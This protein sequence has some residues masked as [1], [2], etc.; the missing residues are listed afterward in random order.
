M[1]KALMDRHMYRWQM[2]R[3]RV[4]YIISYHIPYGLWVMA[5]TQIPNY[6]TRSLANN[7]KSKNQELSSLFMTH[8]IN[9][10]HALIKFPEYIPYGLGV[11]ART[12][13]GTYRR[14]DTS[15]QWDACTHKVS[16]IYSI[17]FRSYGLDMKWDVWTDR[18]TDGQMDGRTDGDVRDGQG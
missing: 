14:T 12:R 4:I 1:Y 7:L 8:R 2:D 9:G 18:L 17:R 3:W 6:E 5:S 16:W 10:M 13:S 11:M 15:Y